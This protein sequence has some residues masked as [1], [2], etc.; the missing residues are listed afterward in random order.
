MT[1]PLV[2]TTT[3]STLPP[4]VGT[5]SLE[6]EYPHMNPEAIEKE[7]E[8][9][10]GE[11]LK[12]LEEITPFPA[13]PRYQEIMKIKEVIRQSK[14]PIVPPREPIDWSKIKEEPAYD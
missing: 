2:F 12:Y 4:T 1:T 5:S 6:A 13:M 10:L 9:K 7:E 8:R 11:A 14:P 3:S